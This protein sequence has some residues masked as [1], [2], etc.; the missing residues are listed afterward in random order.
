M[1]PTPHLHPTPGSFGGSP[2]QL[3]SPTPRRELHRP[4]R[5]YDRRENITIVTT[6]E[7]E[8]AYQILRG[9]TKPALAPVQIEWPLLPQVWVLALVPSGT[10]VATLGNVKTS[11]YTGQPW[12]TGR[13]RNTSISLQSLSNRHFFYCSKS[14][15][16]KK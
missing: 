1:N 15:S 12:S 4:G 10:S 2:T 13:A 14:G 7:R 9:T 16:Q 5:A 6:G 8:V 11:V 3:S